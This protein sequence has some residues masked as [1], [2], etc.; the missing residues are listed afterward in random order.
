MEAAVL[1]KGPLFDLALANP[2]FMD[3]ILTTAAMHRLATQPNTCKKEAYAQVIMHKGIRI[4]PAIVENLNAP[5]QDNCVMLLASTI[6]LTIWAF[7][8]IHL[9]PQANLFTTPEFAAQAPSPV[10]MSTTSSP[11]LDQFLTVATFAGGT[12]AV[13]M[14]MR[15]EIYNS[16]FSEMIAATPWETLAPPPQNVVYGLNALEAHARSLTDDLGAEIT[17]EYVIQIQRLHQMFQASQARVWSDTVVGFAVRLTKIMT[18]Q[19]AKRQPLALTILAY[20]TAALK[21]V[22][23]TWWVKD[24]PKAVFQE[25]TE[26]LDADWRAHLRVPA[27]YFE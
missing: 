10:E 4:I 9:P 24:W 20:W 27:K 22:D 19:L 15:T 21:T 16:G 25:I 3:A 17:D 26:V 11:R 23:D 5:S 7:G 1:W 13:V 18:T 14:A 8:S 6:L 2:S 12:Y